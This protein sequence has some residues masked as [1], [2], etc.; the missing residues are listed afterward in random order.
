VNNW[1]WLQHW[2]YPFH[3]DDWCLNRLQYRDLN[4]ESSIIGPCKLTGTLYRD[5]T[6]S[7]LTER[8]YFFLKTHLWGKGSIYKKRIIISFIFV[9]KTIA[10]VF[11]QLFFK[12][13][14]YR[15]GQISIGK[16]RYLWRII[17]A[18]PFLVLPFKGRVSFGQRDDVFPTANA[19][20][21]QSNHEVS[22]PQQ[23]ESLKMEIQCVF[24][25]QWI[26]CRSYE[27]ES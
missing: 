15:E 2:L 1:W 27:P 7:A 14:P 25:A 12:G 24:I 19:L 21:L 16:G 18:L 13:R 23:D 5:C 17:I 4:P 26:E 10:L 22:A 11:D 3:R 20:S 6:S 9:E 8:N